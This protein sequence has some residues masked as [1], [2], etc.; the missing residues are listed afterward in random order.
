MRALPNTH[1]KLLVVDD[2]ANT[3]QL[4]SEALE[5]CG[6]KVRVSASAR[7][8]QHTLAT[9][10]P[11]LVISDIGMPREDGY[12]L[13]RRVRHLPPDE[14]G[15]TPAIACTGYTRA[16]DRERA[17]HAGF[18]AVVGKPVDIDVLLD[19]IVHVTGVRGLGPEGGDGG[20]PA[21]GACGAS[22]ALPSARARSAP[23]S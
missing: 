15:K 4:L 16:E 10:H 1:L 3:R 11:D 13:I 5:I 9:W 14:G 8:A 20:P 7:E 19:T 17:M 21:P 23:D 2:D 22:A 12:E 6:A 18:D